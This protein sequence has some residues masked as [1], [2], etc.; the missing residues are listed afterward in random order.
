MKPGSLHA[1]AWA[2]ILRAAGSERCCV[3]LAVK[4]QGESKRSL[5]GTK[6]LPTSVM[7]IDTGSACGQALGSSVGGTSTIVGGG[8]VFQEF[9]LAATFT[10]SRWGR[11]WFGGQGGADRASGGW[12]DGGCSPV[13][14]KGAVPCQGH[15]WM[16]RQ[17]MPA[18]RLCICEHTATKKTLLTLFLKVC[19]PTLTSQVRRTRHPHMRKKK[20]TEKRLID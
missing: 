20:H 18:D 8:A 16:L 17:R 15:A 7:P 12:K 2:R 9:I 13:K 6:V 19:C 3:W 4:R 1:P 5:S 14:V 10:N 11:L